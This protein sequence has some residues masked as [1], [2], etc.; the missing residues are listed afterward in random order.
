MCSFHRNIVREKLFKPAN[1]EFEW[2][3]E[4]SGKGK[5]SVLERDDQICGCPLFNWE[6]VM[7]DQFGTKPISLGSRVGDIYID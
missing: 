2:A 6:I 4:I 7:V 3:M 5:G 1:Q